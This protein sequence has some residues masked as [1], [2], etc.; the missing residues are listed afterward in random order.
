MM[1]DPDIAEP[2]LPDFVL[3]KVKPTEKRVPRDELFKKADAANA[4]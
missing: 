1:S 3:E 2:A 4:A